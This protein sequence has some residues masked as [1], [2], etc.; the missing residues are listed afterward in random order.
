MSLLSWLQDDVVAYAVF[1]HME[2]NDD[3]SFNYKA[4]KSIDSLLLPRYGI[5]DIHLDIYNVLIESN[6]LELIIISREHAKTTLLQIFTLWTVVFKRKHFIQI[7]S[8]SIPQAKL[9]LDTISNELLTNPYIL[10]LAGNLQAKQRRQT[11]VRNR[12]SS[13]F[14]L[15]NTNV[16]L[17]IMGWGQKPRGRKFRGWRPDL[18]VFD[19]FES[20]DNTNTL[21]LRQKLRATIYRKILPMIDEY[22]GQQVFLG[23]SVH[24]DSFLE[25]T[26]MAYQQC[27]LKGE[28]SAWHVIRKDVEVNQVFLWPK[29]YDAAWLK[30]KR[31]LYEEAGELDALYQEYYNQAVSEKSRKF[32]QH[33]LFWKG[34][35]EW[36]NRIPWLT[37]NKYRRVDP[38]STPAG[39]YG[40]LE[41]LGKFEVPIAIY[42]GIDMGW[43]Q[44]EK[45]D[46]SAIEVIGV[47]HEENGYSLEDLSGRFDHGE[48]LENLSWAQKIYNVELWTTESNGAQ[49]LAMNAMLLS[50]NMHQ[51]NLT[52]THEH[53]AKNKRIERLLPRARRGK[54]FLCLTH[55]R[56][57]EDFDQYP[58]PRRFDRLD[59][60]EKAFRNSNPAP[61][62]KLLQP[63]QEYDNFGYDEIEPENELTEAWNTL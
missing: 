61:H 42:G 30:R 41:D 23:T 39:E 58:K 27:Q 46:L 19:D 60:I 28:K 16:A 21:P 53:V 7:F 17:E 9:W 29:R 31:M 50:Q 40:L 59:A 63:T 32:K 43:T 44:S 49:E 14:L 36:R 45:S 55:K 51:Y 3:G 2:R 20:E 10:F 12:W 18:Q 54:L 15:T 33:I 8:E 5:P 52:Y 25:R 13:Y 24:P 56:L 6:R 48:I 11:K 35:I 62:P 47:D 26:W 22:D 34:K 38:K 37:G 4:K 57:I 1:C